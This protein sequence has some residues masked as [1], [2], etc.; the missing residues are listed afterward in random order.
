MLISIDISLTSPQS[1]D[2]ETSKKQALFLG[3]HL[4]D[5]NED[6]YHGLPK[7]PRTWGE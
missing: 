2:G 4:E 6:K 3:R 1:Y 7:D 5:L